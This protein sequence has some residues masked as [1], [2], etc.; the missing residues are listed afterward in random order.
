LKRYIVEMRYKPM[1]RYR[2]GAIVDPSATSA[3]G[4]LLPQPLVTTRDGAS[5]LLDEVLGPWFALFTWC[6]D[7]WPHLDEDARRIW[8]TLGGNVVVCR[9]MTQLHWEEQGE[10]EFSVVGDQ[11]G[12]VKSWFDSGEGSV[13]V[14]RP[15]RFVAVVARPAEIAHKLR[16]FAA[17]LGVR[18][19]AEHQPR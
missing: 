11:T 4:T 7:P 6:S 17:L 13:V 2:G 16:R 1:P 3:V 8:K 5:V 19:E 14:V 9:P 18:P 12:A 15:D 10:G